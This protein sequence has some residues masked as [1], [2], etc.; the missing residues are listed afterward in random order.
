M[1]MLRLASILS[2][3][4]SVVAATAALATPAAAQIT[5]ALPPALSMPATPVLKR[6]VTVAGDLVRIGD[7][8]ENAGS[9]ARVPIF[10]APDLGQT[11]TVSAARVM[12]ALRPHGFTIVE[13][14]GIS[15]I[16]VTRAARTFTVKD[17]EARIAAELA[18]QFGLG[19]AKNLTVTIERDAKPVQIEPN[20]GELQVGRVFYDRSGRFDVT[21]DVPGSSA[22]RRTPL[23]FT[24]TVVETV[25]TAVLARALNRSD[26]IK[27]SDVAIE[28]RP[29][30][31]LR[32][33]INATG[34]G[35]VGLAAKRAL[36]AGEVLHAADFVKPEIVQ[37]NENVTLVYE[38]PGLLLTMR[39]KALESGALGDTV[40]VLNIQSKRTIQGTISGP[41]QV[42]VTA[43]TRVS[44]QVT[45]QS[46]T[47]GETARS[48]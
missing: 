47:S 15:E 35:L 6:D 18:G 26:V 1:A 7:V 30:V 46:E 43:S 31:E 13:T 19:E 9:S 42:S 27:A 3:M 40:N 36:R 45:A 2:A 16:A 33:D 25:E 38:A 12:E 48:E 10:R 22:A 21:F 20:A 5:G 8:V 11:G 39:G 14:R 23:R 29:K 4:V 28:R 24:G 32:G 17:L 37:R 41:G 44:R 34:S